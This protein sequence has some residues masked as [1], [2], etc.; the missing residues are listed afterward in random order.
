MVNTIDDIARQTNLLAVNASIEA[1]RAGD[2]GRGFAIIAHEVRELSGRTFEATKQ[3]SSRVETLMSEI[4]A[5]DE[6]VQS[7]GTVTNDASTELSALEAEQTRMID[8]IAEVDTRMEQITS[9]ICL[10]SRAAG[11]MQHTVADVNT[12]AKFCVRDAESANVVLGRSVTEIGKRLAATAEL[13]IPNKVLYL[14]KADHVIWKK[15]LA[16]MFSNQLQLKASELSDHRMCRLGKWYYSA[17]KDLFGMQEAFR[18][19]E[20]PHREVHAAGIRAVQAFNA[21]SPA[22]ALQEMSK[23]EAASADVLALLDRLIASTGQIGRALLHRA[24]I[25]PK[26]CAPLIAFA[27]V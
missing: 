13:D 19:L 7:A 25:A 1:A 21:G 9:A 10:Q 24:A 16:D 4:G 8:Q 2:A 23:V 20:A 12:A 14:A 6:S 18:A 5:I 3:I 27:D 15:R 22:E 17:G 26:R 11:D